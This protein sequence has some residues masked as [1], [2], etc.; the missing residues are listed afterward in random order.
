M[1]IFQTIILGIVEGLTEFLPISSTFHLIFA[2]KFLGLADTDAQKVFE[3]VIQGGAILPVVFLYGREW[4][5]NKQ[6]LL[7]IGV[8]FLPTAIVGVLLHKVIKELF[9]T[10]SLLMIGMFILV[11]LGFL[12][13]EWAIHQN[14]LQLSRAL[15]T[16]SWK[17]A[18]LIGFAQS[19]AVIPGVS[20]A[21]AVMVI[22]MLLGFKR[23]QAAKYSFSLAVPTILA[24]AGFDLLKMHSVVLAQASTLVPSLMI[25]SI[26]AFITSFAVI[27]WF[28]GFL[29]QRT[30][31]TFGVY[32]VVAGS[33]LLLLAR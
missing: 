13:V 11:G 15:E 10:N 9:F 16:L 21:G 20:R 25:G 7:K 8:S 3:V 14:K 6:S 2:S 4:L 1:N 26:V 27:T 22:M 29:R 12:A 19:L 33:V 18:V 5:K 28:I 23:D 17:E 32:R 31:N 30:L 24:A